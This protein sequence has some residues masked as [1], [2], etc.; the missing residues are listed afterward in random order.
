MDGRVLNGEG[1]KTCCCKK[2]NYEIG[3]RVTPGEGH[4]A[5]R[6]DGLERT[7]CGRNGGEEA[8]RARRGR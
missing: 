1:C 8:A 6:E 7:D 2:M 3:E 5:G 4:E